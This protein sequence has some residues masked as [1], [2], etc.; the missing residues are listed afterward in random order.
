MRGKVATIYGWVVGK[1]AGGGEAR[2]R[3]AA[4]LTRPRHRLDAG[5][6][7]LLATFWVFVKPKQFASSAQFDEAKHK[8]G[9]C[10]TGVFEIFQF[11][12][13]YMIARVAAPSACNAHRD[14]LLT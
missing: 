5:S 4:A 9:L 12:A 3:S 2:G 13:F 8:F 11:L 7:W 1:W 14:E 10:C 6:M